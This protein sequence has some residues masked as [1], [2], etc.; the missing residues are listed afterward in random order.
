MKHTVTVTGQGTVTVVP[1]HAVVRVAAQHRADSVEAACAGVASAVEAVGAVARRFT[2]SARIGSSDFGVWPALDRSGEPAGF[3]ARHGLSVSL[4][5]LAAAGG[6]ISALAAEVGDRLRVDSVSLEVDDPIEARD[7]A[8]AAAFEEA[9]RRAEQL[10]ALGGASLGK[11]VAI[12]E[13]DGAGAPREVFAMAKAAADTS[14][15]P[16]ERSLAASV[17]VTWRLTR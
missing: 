10:A 14:F 5:D 15:E 9:R 13:G 6:L 12:V 17:T 16:G 8:R 11:V 3:E 2:E 7:R 4:S 1:D